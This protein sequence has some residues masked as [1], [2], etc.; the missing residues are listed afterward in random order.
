MLDRNNK[1]HT[2]KRPEEKEKKRK[3]EEDWRVKKAHSKGEKRK[4]EDAKKNVHG[5][6]D[7]KKEA[8]KR[9]APAYHHVA[10]GSSILS[11]MMAARW[12]LEVAAAIFSL[13]MDTGASSPPPKKR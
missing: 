4:R 1:K 13:A 9:R 8:R 3:R 6:R 2:Q 11:C 5:K 7:E 12:A 10:S